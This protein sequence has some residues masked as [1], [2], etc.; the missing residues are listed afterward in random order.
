M[1]SR[2]YDTVGEED[3]SLGN[4]RKQRDLDHHSVHRL[5]IVESVACLW[6]DRHRH[7]PC[8]DCKTVSRPLIFSALY[9]TCL[10]GGEERC[11]QAGTGIV[12]L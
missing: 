8:R 6:T 5:E 9:H 2:V 10:K 12:P 11:E 1:L 3:R 4:V 7:V